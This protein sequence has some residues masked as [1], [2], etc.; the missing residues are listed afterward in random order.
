MQYFTIFQ[1]KLHSFNI[2]NRTKHAWACSKT[3][4]K[5]SKITYT[6]S[7][8]SILASTKFSVNIKRVTP[9]HNKDFIVMIIYFFYLMVLP[10]LW[11]AK[12][13]CRAPWVSKSTHPRKFGNHV[14]V[15]RPPAARPSAPQGNQCLI[16]HFL[17][18]LGAQE[19]WYC[20]HI[21]HQ[22]CDQLTAV[23]TGS[24]WPV[25]PYRIAGSGVDPSRSSMF[26]SYPL[27]SY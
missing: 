20:T 13:A 15:H 2:Q 12:R 1:D 11:R 23:K 7:R 19:D 5:I 6:A 18:S 8:F 26:W 3:V 27:T 25:S 10:E 14:T 16:P 9:Q 22:C 21:A 4:Q 17:A 24:R